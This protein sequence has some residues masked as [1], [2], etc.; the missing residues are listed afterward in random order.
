MPI[1]KDLIGYEIYK[2]VASKDYG[3]AVSMYD[4]N[5]DSTST[6]LTAVWMYLKPTNIMIRIPGQSDNTI[7]EVLFWKNVDDIDDDIRSIISRLRTTCNLF[8][9]GFTIKDFSS[10]NKTKDFYSI[11]QRQQEEEELSNM[12]SSMVNEAFTGSVKRSVLPSGN[13]NLVIYHSKPVDDNVHGARARNVKEIFIDCAGE[14]YRYDINHVP[15]ARI[16]VKYIGSGG[17][18]NDRFSNYIKESA[19][20]MLEYRKFLKENP[21]SKLCG[22]VTRYH[23][24][25]MESFK[26][27]QSNRGLNLVRE[28]VMSRKPFAKNLIEQRSKIL[29]GAMPMNE[30]EGCCNIVGYVAKRDI[31]DDMSHIPTYRSIIET[32]LP[33]LPKKDANVLSNRIGKCLVLG[34]AQPISSSFSDIGSYASDLSEMVND[35]RLKQVLLTIG[36]SGV[37]SRDAAQF[38][39]GIAKSLKLN[40][41]VIE[42]DDQPEI[43]EL[44][45]FLNQ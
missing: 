39:F 23:N 15:S 1:N 4:E 28:G 43:N 42:R 14:R 33:E 20:E 13:A 41:P 16:L 5:G 45:G 35:R 17:D 40:D 32:C 36:N 3:Y 34:K 24:E 18:F 27:M 26:Q 37:N 7:N 11:F 12:E 6:P 10:E 38:V 25:I 22:R 30:A 19:K 9:T 21:K 44:K 29:S 31:I 8:G 2:V